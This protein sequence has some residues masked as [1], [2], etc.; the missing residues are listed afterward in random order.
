MS[1]RSIVFAAAIVAAVA[2]PASA[3]RA[4]GN[5]ELL[6]EAQVAFR[7][8]SDAIQ[9][10]R[11]E[12]FYRAKS[13]RRLR[14]VIEGGEVRLRNIKLVYL[15][16]HVEDLGISRTMKPGE[17]FDIDLRGERSYLKEIVLDH[18][19]KF[20]L[21]LGQGG[22]RIAK[23]RIKVFGDNVR[24]GGPPVVAEPRRPSR[25]WD[26]LAKER[27]DRRDDRVVMNVG[28][29]EGRLGQIALRHEGESILIRELRIRFGNGE[30]QTVSLDARL[31]DGDLTRPIDLEGERRFIERVTIILDPRQRPGA[32]K[33]SLL[34]LDRP[35]DDL[36]EDLRRNDDRRDDRPGVR[37]R[38]GWIPLG[39]QTVNLGLDRDIIE[40]GDLDEGRRARGFDRLHFIAENNDL[41]LRT[42]R[43]VYV[44]GYSEDQRIDRVIPAGGDLAVDLPGRRSYIRR[45][46]MEYSA[47]PGFRGQSIIS[48]FGETVGRE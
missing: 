32:V 10:G 48:V 43:I 24:R 13:Y 39:R 9:L 19:G 20:G 44:N 36:R 26:E 45:I 25:E 46:E 2:V 47:R 17:E 8:D 40:I 6:G 30:T 34:G 31:R 4:G 22:I 28:R 33:L 18:K 1:L 41:A 15:N 21:S 38:E 42:L 12:E 37:P 35:G 27:F 16:G 11:D 29:R 5:W 7:G 23:P 3:Q 14:F